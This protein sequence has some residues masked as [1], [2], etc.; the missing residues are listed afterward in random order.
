M[1]KALLL[2][3]HIWSDIE[4]GMMSYGVGMTVGLSIF[5]GGDYIKGCL[6]KNS[7]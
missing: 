6:D 3:L 2:R 7:F 5:F 4:S 1:V